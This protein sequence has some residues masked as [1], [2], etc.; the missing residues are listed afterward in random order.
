MASKFS[1]PSLNSA[2]NPLSMAARAIFFSG[3]DNSCIA[4]ILG[5][6]TEKKEQNLSIHLSVKKII[7][8]KYYD[9]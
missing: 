1:S 5:K 7:L 4:K 8:S 6:G 2:S 9:P 3:F